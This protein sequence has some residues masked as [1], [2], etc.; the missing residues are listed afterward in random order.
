MD[1]KAF[2]EQIFELASYMA[3]SARN[4][5]N[6]P[7][8]YGPLRLVDSVSRL[9]EVLEAHDLGSPRLGLLRDKIDE[10]KYSVMESEE[11]FLE[12]LESVV[13]HLAEE[14]GKEEG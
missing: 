13:M 8:A 6:E 5:L 12:F 7:A 1:K 9:V 11:A 14:I 2:E 10:G 4:L 3:V